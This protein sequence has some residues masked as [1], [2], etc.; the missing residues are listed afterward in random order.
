MS[1]FPFICSRNCRFCSAGVWGVIIKISRCAF[2]IVNL[3]IQISWQ[4]TKVITIRNKPDLLSIQNSLICICFSIT[5]VLKIINST[6]L[7]LF[8]R[9][10]VTFR[11]D[12]GNIFFN[13]ER[14]IPTQLV[15]AQ[16]LLRCHTTLQEK[17][18]TITLEVSLYQVKCTEQKQTKSNTLEVLHTFFLTSFQQLIVGIQLFWMLAIECLSRICLD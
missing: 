3:K 9:N 4:R 8:E 6:R 14:R 5:D 17:T 16:P 10:Y 1:Q 2:L 11:R 18:P 13:I 7:I 12:Y 15:R